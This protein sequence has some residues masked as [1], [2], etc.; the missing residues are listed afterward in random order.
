M[1]GSR[2]VAAV[3]QAE[4]REALPAPRYFQALH[5]DQYRAAEFKVLNPAGLGTSRSGTG[6]STQTLFY[7]LLAGR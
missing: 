1:S 4:P 6:S 3:A 7:Y 2:S 5:D